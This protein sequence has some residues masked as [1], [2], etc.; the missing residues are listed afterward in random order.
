MIITG[1]ELTGGVGRISGGDGGIVPA[2]PFPNRLSLDFDGV[3]ECVDFGNVLNR[4]AQ[5]A[6]SMFLW[7]KTTSTG[8]TDTLVAKQTVFGGQEGYR[9]YFDGTNQRFYI[10]LRALAGQLSALSHGAMNKNDGNWHL[11]GFTYDGSENV[12]GLKVYFDNTAENITPIANTLSGSLSNTTPLL[13][14]SF[15]R[16]APAINPIDATMKDLSIWGAALTPTQVTTELW[17]GGEPGDLDAHSAVADRDLWARLG[18]GPG[19]TYPT[20]A[21]QSGNGYDGAMIAMD[22]SN[23]VEDSP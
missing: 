9:L 8:T 7:Y 14:S 4:G 1:G 18:D 15:F 19:D 21:D 20:V 17:N 11:V 3:A 5:E 2:E 13:L 16:N 10:I 6:F 23:F 12:S 22:A